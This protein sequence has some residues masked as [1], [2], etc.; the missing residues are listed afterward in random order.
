MKGTLI[1]L[2]VLPGI[3]FGVMAEEP[4]Q[5]FFESGRVDVMAGLSTHEG[6]SGYFVTGQWNISQYA[7]LGLGVDSYTSRNSYP[8]AA[9]TDNALF[10][11]RSFRPRHT[12]Y[13]LSGTVRYPF[14]LSDDS[15]AAPF[16]TIGFNQMST[17]DVEIGDGTGS[18]SDD[19]GSSNQ[20][21]NILVL[22]F[23]DLDA[24]SLHAGAQ[25]QINK[26]HLLGAGFVAYSLDDDWS[27]LSIEDQYEGGFISYRYQYTPLLGFT[28]GVETVDIFGDANARMG[29]TFSF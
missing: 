4:A 19:S 17:E 16:F 20:N 18:N 10:A 27:E 29:V 9:F 25:W 2:A 26:K 13:S 3:T 11:S 12:T 1:A 6:E 8:A 21:Q 23:A 24:F 15:Y 5:D 7:A 14:S 28:A 22:S